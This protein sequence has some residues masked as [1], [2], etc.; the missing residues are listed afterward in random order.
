[1]ES[2]GG[3]GARPRSGGSGG[4]GSA[5]D[6]GLGL[7]A[8]REVGRLA[9]RGGRAG[10]L[11][12]RVAGAQGVEGHRRGDLAGPQADPGARLAAVRWRP[13]PRPSGHRPAR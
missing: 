11:P 4:G 7:L 9:V 2:G 13:R 8:G 12:L 3:L 1:M 5:Q 6:L 10:G